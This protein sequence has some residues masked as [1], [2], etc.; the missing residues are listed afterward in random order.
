MF[1]PE[2]GFSHR[3]GPFDEGF[4]VTLSL[5]SKDYEYT[6]LKSMLPTYCNLP[7]RMY[8]PAFVVSNL[9]PDSSSTY[10]CIRALSITM[11]S[12]VTDALHAEN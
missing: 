11:V 3:K 2:I 7:S 5:I 8:D 9:N 6:S 4:D 10:S 1:T 12:V